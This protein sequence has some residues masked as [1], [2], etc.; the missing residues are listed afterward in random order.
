MRWISIAYAG[1]REARFQTDQSAL[2]QQA[3]TIGI[4]VVNP[5]RCALKPSR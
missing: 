5:P 4:E 2:P 1:K 3:S